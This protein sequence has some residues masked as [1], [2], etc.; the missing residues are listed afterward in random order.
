MG[1]RSHMED[2]VLVHDLLPCHQHL[3]PGVH[4]AVVV[5]V[6]DGHAGVGLLH[7][8]VVVGVV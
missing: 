6:F 2:R 4:R 8:A 3:F 7:R 1:K 5:G